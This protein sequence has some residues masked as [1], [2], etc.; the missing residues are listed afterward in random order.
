LKEVREILES[1]GLV[2]NKKKSVE[3]KEQIQF[4]GYIV[5]KDISS[6]L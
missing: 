5:G 4:L 6:L 2:E 1:Y 3:R